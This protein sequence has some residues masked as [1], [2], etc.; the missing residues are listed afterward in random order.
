MKKTLILM[1]GFL[2]IG[3]NLYAA[4][5]LIVE[6]NVGI[7]TTSPTVE[8][9]MNGAAIFNESGSDKDFRIESDTDPN[10]FF[11]DAGNNRIH[12]GIIKGTAKL[13][14][15]YAVDGQTAL[16]STVVGAAA[17]DAIYGGV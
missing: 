16:S 5:D 9:D 13:G 1:L 10:A 11:M 14:V 2:L 7:G 6:G 17:A 8:F 15:G 3:I 4:G 12:I